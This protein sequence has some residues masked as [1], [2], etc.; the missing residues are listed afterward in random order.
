MSKLPDAFVWKDPEP[1]ADWGTVNSEVRRTLRNHPGH[2]A[3]VAHIGHRSAADYY[4]KTFGPRG[5]EFQTRLRREKNSYEL[6]ARYS[7]DNVDNYDPARDLE[8]GSH[9]EAEANR[10]GD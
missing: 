1:R 8:P 7:P 2:W 6:F 5:F 3:S 10:D 9:E 4:R